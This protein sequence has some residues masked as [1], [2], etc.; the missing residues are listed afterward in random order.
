MT[1]AGDIQWAL[2]LLQAAAE[3]RMLD[4]AT[5]SRPGEVVVDPLTGRDET[6]LEEVWAGPCRVSSQQPYE[7]NREAG[8][9][10]WSTQR[11]SVHVPVSAPSPV[12]GDVMDVT[13]A[14]GGPARRFRVAAIHR[15][16][17]QTAQRVSVEEVTS[18]DE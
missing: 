14:A 2:P 16:T 4:T 18:W 7:M 13:P 3:S 9:A 5:L 15:V 1:L 17:Q 11:Y 12:E 6:S 8:E 10:T